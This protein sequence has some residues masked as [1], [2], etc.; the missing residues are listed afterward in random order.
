MVFGLIDCNNFYV[1]CER[2]FRPDLEGKPVIVLS[3]ND[4]CAIARSAESKALGIK[5]GDPEFKLRE[6]IQR[7]KI[8]VFSSNYSLYGDMSRRVTDVLHSMVP[9]VETYSIDE[10]FLS[11]GEFPALD[12]EA[13]A[14]ELRARVLQWVGVPTCVGFGPTKT[15]AKV[16]NFLAKKRPQFRGVCD[17]RSAET[18]AELLPTVPVEEIWGVGKAS[19]AK[20]AKLGITTAADLAALGPD[21]AC[22]LMTVTGGRTVY[23]LRGTSCMPLE[24]VEPTRKGIAVTRSFGKPVLTWQLMHE[25]VVSYAARAAE[26]LRHHH[27]STWNIGVFMHTSAHNDDPW[28][29][30]GASESL[31]EATNDT[32]E[33]VSIAARLGE[34][35]WRD[36]FRY[37]KA[38]ILLTDLVPKTTQ[39]AALWPRAD[40]ERRAKLWQ[41][42]DE[43]NQSL[44]R[45]TVKPLGSGLQQTW[46]LR[47]VHRSPRWTTHWEE[48]PCAKAI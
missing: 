16:A 25:A 36:G 23:E 19:V 4:G 24:L 12:V 15:L 17:L 13:L 40:R 46:K 22:A 48:L 37:V 45:G 35:C 10:S 14:R 27:V 11:L 5:M 39:Q 34:R 29:S 3:N 20:L 43:L 47:A 30:K 38:G 33:L 18:R 21:D 6:L 9:E 32:G 8:K 28:Y 26:K 1:S 41:V 31:Q 44:G 2:V 7:E 42:V